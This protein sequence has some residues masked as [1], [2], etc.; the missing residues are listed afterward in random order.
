VDTS[1]DAVF[2]RSSV[3]VKVFTVLVLQYTGHNGHILLMYLGNVIMVIKKRILEKHTGVD[4]GS[5]V[6]C[7]V[8]VSSG[9]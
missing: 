8:L 6:S 9:K 4:V 2:L 7:P 3:R 5:V 1:P